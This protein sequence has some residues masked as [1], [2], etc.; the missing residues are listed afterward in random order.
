[1]SDDDDGDDRLSRQSGNVHLWSMCAK[2]AFSSAIVGAQ[3]ADSIDCVKEERRGN[4]RAEKVGRKERRR[5]WPQCR[6]S[7]V[8]KEKETGK[9]WGLS[10][11][12]TQTD[13]CCA[14]LLGECLGHIH[15]STFFTTHSSDNLALQHTNLI[16]GW[17]DEANNARI[18]R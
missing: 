13:P 11:L 5:K 18:A 17:A 3:A 1:M 8:V 2:S 16:T 9:P 15:T 12:C 10:Y 7:Q 6:G 4:M 14:G